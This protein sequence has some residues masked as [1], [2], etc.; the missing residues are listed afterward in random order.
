M[1]P[2]NAVL[3]TWANWC[4]TD[5]LG[6]GKRKNRPGVQ[7]VREMSGRVGMWT[8]LQ[9]RFEHG[10]GGWY[11]CTLGFALLTDLWHLCDYKKSKVNSWYR[12]GPAPYCHPLQTWLCI[13]TILV[14]GWL[15]LDIHTRAWPPPNKLACPGAGFQECVCL[16]SPGDSDLVG[17]SSDPIPKTKK[18]RPRT[19]HVLPLGTYC[20]FI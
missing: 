5:V 8:S 16:W 12:V 6:D 13:K 14:V 10:I 15:A 4:V 9:V 19:G 17:Y 7:K 18:L 20:G 11:E 3:H 2:N 1:T